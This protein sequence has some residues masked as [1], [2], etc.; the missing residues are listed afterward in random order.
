MP[1]FIEK[2]KKSGK[3]LNTQLLANLTFQKKST[4]YL[5]KSVFKLASVL[6]RYV[7]SN[8][9]KISAQKVEH[10]CQMII[11]FFLNETLVGI[12]KP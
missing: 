6:Q 12:L 1:R 4:Y 7:H 8:I 5:C 3:R 2:N 10:K 9:G 11:I